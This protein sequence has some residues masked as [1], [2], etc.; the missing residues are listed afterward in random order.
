LIAGTYVFSLVVKDNS[1]LSSDPDQVTVTVS[2]GSTGTGTTARINTGGSAVSAGG[3]SWTGDTYYTDTDPTYPSRSYTSTGT[4]SNTNMPVIYQTERYGSSFTYNVPVTNG[5][6]QVKLHF[7]ELYWNTAG[8]RIFNVNVE[9]GQGMVS[10]LDVYTEAG[11]N[12]ALVKTFNASV[13][14]GTMTIQFIAVK[15]MAKINAIEIIPVTTNEVKPVANAGPDKSITLPTNSVTLDGSGTDADG[16]VVTYSWSQVS[17]PNSAVFSSSSVAAPTVSGLVAGTYVFSLIV[18]D[19]SNLSSDPDQVTVTVNSGSTGTGTTARINAGGPALSI[20]GVTWSADQYYTDV[21]SAEPSRTTYYNT[22]IANT[23]SQEVYK[24]ER[25]GK[26]FHY[27]VPMANGSYQVRLHFA[28]NYWSSTGQRVMNVDIENSQGKLTNFDIL[29]ETSK[30]TALI[31]EFNVTVSD[32]TLNIQIT[33]VLDNAKISGIEI[34]PATA[35]PPP[36][37]SAL[38][39]INSGGPETIDNE[40][41]WNADKHY[42]T[43]ISYTYRSSATITNTTNQELYRTERYGKTFSYIIP[44]PIG[45][46]E[47]RLHFAELYWTTTGSRVFDV[48]VENGQGTLTNFDIYAQAGKNNPLVKSFA[49]NCSDGNINI[50]LTAINDN[51]KIS[52]IEVLQTTNTARSGISEMT[53]SPETKGKLQVKASPNPSANDFLITFETADTAHVDL[54]VVNASGRVI[55]R[56]SKL[57][58]S[59][60]IRIGQGYT[61][62]TYF[63]EARQGAERTVVTVIKH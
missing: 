61:R 39:R 12:S 27:N 29:A 9:N 17:G 52:G 62:G 38:L 63:I 58:P 14:D 41:T 16:T 51:A 45:S 5:S 1:N 8:Q 57:D 31:K 35:P 54:R 24:S 42:S 43:E 4:I 20:D 53:M 56:L 50:A 36:P 28:E 13:S 34:L 22:S 26:A 3:F 15:D 47:V 7:A 48:N 23:T 49:V 6:Y 37:P 44:V 18:I 46:Y 33:A 30:N 59:R 11:K 60:N 19:N 32:S 55:D 2:S 40:V 21:N 10:N 25:Y